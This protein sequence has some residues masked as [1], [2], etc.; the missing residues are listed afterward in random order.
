M[1]IV[2]SLRF[3][4]NFRKLALTCDT[5]N[6]TKT[7]VLE[8]RLCSGVGLEVEMK[9]GLELGTGLELGLGDGLRQDWA[10]D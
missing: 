6:K 7:R 4:G 1:L 8:E 3:P 9:L 2:A 5:N 10:L